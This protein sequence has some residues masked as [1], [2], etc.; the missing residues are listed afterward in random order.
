MLG[1]TPGNQHYHEAELL[2]P[3]H[4]NFSS[5]VVGKV[6]VFSAMFPLSIPY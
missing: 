6:K 4:N 3:F 5:E 1:V 2:K